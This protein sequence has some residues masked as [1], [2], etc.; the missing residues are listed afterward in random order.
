MAEDTQGEVLEAVAKLKADMQNANTYRDVGGGVKLQNTIEAPRVTVWDKFGRT[1]R[2]P[3]TALTYHLTK[4]DR[5]GNRVFF[6][7]PPEGIVPPTP[8]DAKCDICL[9]RGV[10]KVFYSE[11]DYIGHMDTFHPREYAVMREREREKA[12]A[13]DRNLLR[14]VLLSTKAEA[15][16]PESVGIKCENCDFVAKSEFGLKAHIRAKHGGL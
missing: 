15:V 5:Q 4:T 9:L 13:E 1:S 6:D 3:L 2:V 11:F 7:K 12:Q 8:I 14:Q 16:P 10:K